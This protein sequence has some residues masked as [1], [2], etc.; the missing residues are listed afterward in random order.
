MT[1]KNMKKLV[2]GI[3]LTLALISTMAV[4]ASGQLK[5]KIEVVYDDIK[6]VVDSKTVR[7]GKDGAGQQI[8]PFIHNGTTYLPVR[9]VGEAIG[10]DVN[11]NQNTKTV[12]IGEKP[13]DINYLTEMLAPSN[14]ASIDIF[15]LGSKSKL[16][17]KGHDYQTGFKR[18]ANATNSYLVFNLDSKYKE[19]S[20]DYG[21][22]AQYDHA[23]EIEISL[24]N[25][26]K[27]VYSVNQGDDVK[28]VKIDVT[29]VDKLQ[30]HFGY[31]N[32]ASPA[33]GDPILK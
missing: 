27:H 9:A 24:N 6:L 13:E 2:F 17:I 4:F 16:N 21:P 10:R 33:I 12:S 32:F 25:S 29:G 1:K 18:G 20:F 23:G 14:S 26:I 11:W 5:K 30:F 22:T 15:S 31:Y 3:V 28:S 19:L 8:E 7:F